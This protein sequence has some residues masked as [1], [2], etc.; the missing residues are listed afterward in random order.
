M[1]VRTWMLLSLL[2]C[3]PAAG[4]GVWLLTS[5]PHPAQAA[6]EGPFTVDGLTWPAPGHAGTIAP[7]VRQPVTEVLVAEGQRVK[8]DQPLIRLDDEEAVLALKAKKAEMDAQK[9]AVAQIKAKPVHAK[10]D[11]AR[12]LLEKAQ[13]ATES[14]RKKAEMLAPLAKQGVVAE[15]N[16]NAARAEYEQAQAAERA[17]RDKVT[18]ERD[19]PHQQQIWQEEA[20]LRSATADWERARSDLEDYTIKAPIA[21]VV[22]WLKARPG[23]ISR[24]GTDPWGEVL[25]LSE[26]DVRCRLP[27]PDLDR[28]AMGQPAEVFDEAGRHV[29]SGKVV[30]IGVAADRQSERHEVP[31]IVRIQNPEG[32][33]RCYIPVKVRFGKRP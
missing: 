10:V 3:L 1:R 23:M 6:E 20:K 21:G 18:Q 16:Y 15:K 8:K 17:A 24:P 4:S 31:V 30:T 26:L 22:S 14:A 25:D 5:R 2:V 19:T 27:S 28:V 32:R 7:T 12:A 11:E 13:A 29:I 9:E 33:L